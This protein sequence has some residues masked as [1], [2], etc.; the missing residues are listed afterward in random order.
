MKRKRS[1]Q[2]V[3]MPTALFADD[4]CGV[5]GMNMVAPYRLNPSEGEASDMVTEGDTV[6]IQFYPKTKRLGVSH[7]YCGW[8]ALIR[9]IMDL[10][11]RL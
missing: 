2:W 6:T 10:H 7:Y 9:S 1:V 5:C 4:D 3:I 8:G 11:D